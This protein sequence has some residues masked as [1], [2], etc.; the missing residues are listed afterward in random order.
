MELTSLASSISACSSSK[1]VRASSTCS[2]SPRPLCSSIACFQC[3][4]RKH[5]IP[6]T[7]AVRFRIRPTG[8]TLLQQHPVSR[9]YT[10]SMRADLSVLE[11]LKIRTRG[12][13]VEEVCFLTMRN[14]FFQL[15]MVSKTGAHPLAVS[16]IFCN[17]SD[18]HQPLR[19][20]Q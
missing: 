20:L 18:R 9:V 13:V 10:C 5:T 19:R 8:H 7:N 1:R 2:I 14:S 3:T 15:D 4:P 17:M 16:R 11:Y 6:R 12:L